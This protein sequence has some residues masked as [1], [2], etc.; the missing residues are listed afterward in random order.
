MVEAPPPRVVYRV[1][2]DLVGFLGALARM[3]VGPGLY[4]TSWYR[5]EEDNIRVGGAPFSSHRAGLALD[6]AGPPDQ[7]SRLVDDAMYIG[8]AVA[9]PYGTHV[10]LQWLEAGE[11]V[12][13]FPDLFA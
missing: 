1:W 11:A 6:V 5:S 13:R 9:I 10:H 3:P 8:I 4:A 2:G 12:R 7:L